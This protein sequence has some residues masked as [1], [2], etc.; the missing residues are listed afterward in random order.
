[1]KL[2]LNQPDVTCSGALRG[3]FVGE[4]DPLPL[5]KQLEHRPS[6]RAAVKEVLDAVFISDESEPFVDQQ[7][8]DR[9]R[10]HTLLR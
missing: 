5:A 4:L 8:C 7:S 10:G 6:H 3:L 2:A 1:L 9:A